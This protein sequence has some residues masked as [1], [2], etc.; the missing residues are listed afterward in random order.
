MVQVSSHLPA[1]IEAPSKRIRL[2]YFAGVEHTLALYQETGVL[3]TC[4][5]RKEELLFCILRCAAIAHHALPQYMSRLCATYPLR[6]LILQAQ[7]T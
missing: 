7:N 5:V 2:V 3:H 1:S 4:M 6:S